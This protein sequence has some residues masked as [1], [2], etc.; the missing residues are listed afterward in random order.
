MLFRPL[1]CLTAVA[2]L[3]TPALA[4][5]DVKA[6]QGISVTVRGIFSGSLYAQDAT[7]G[8]GNGQKAQYVTG[9]VADWFHGGDVRNMGLTL[10]LAGPEVKRGWRGGRTD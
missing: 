6:N 5:Q 10:G 4:A 3:S 7:F 2:V 8:T 9:E 1:R